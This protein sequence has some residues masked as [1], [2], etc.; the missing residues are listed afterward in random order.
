MVL[1]DWPDLRTNVNQIPTLFKFY[2]TIEL[3]LF[4]FFKKIL[5]YLYK[6]NFKICNNHNVMTD[7]L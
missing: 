6:N 3:R 1:S 2:A 5:V 4:S 7:H